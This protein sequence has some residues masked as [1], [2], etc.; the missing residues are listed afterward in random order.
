MRWTCLL[1]TT[2]IS[3]TF[4]I[5]NKW[6][7]NSQEFGSFVKGSPHLPGFCACRDLD[8]REFDRVFVLG[9]SKIKTPKQTRKLLLV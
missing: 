7:E 2:K 1:K 6:T 8:M 9:C 5:W 4:H 3:I